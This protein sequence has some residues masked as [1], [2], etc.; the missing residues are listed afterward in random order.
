MKNFCNWCHQ[1]DA[2]LASQEKPV[3]QASAKA[4]ICPQCRRGI[5]L[6]TIPK[7]C[8]IVSVSRKTMYQWIDKGLVSTMRSASGRLLICLTSLFGPSNEAINESRR[9]KEKV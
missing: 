4:P 3:V 7:A 6:V 9:P 2:G 5:T 1:G 8:E